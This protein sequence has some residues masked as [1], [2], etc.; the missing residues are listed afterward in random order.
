LID[1]TVRKSTDLF[2]FRFSR[3]CYY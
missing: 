3:C 2:Y 1:K